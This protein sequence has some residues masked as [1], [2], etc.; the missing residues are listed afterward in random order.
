MMVISIPSSGLAALYSAN[1]DDGIDITTE[2]D[3]AIAKDE[4]CWY[5][6]GG[7]PY[8]FDVVNLD[9]PEPTK[10][11]CTIVDKGNDLYA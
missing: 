8:D 7:I 5:R 11:M 10:I 6:K 3:Y 1:P 2:E 4:G 9:P